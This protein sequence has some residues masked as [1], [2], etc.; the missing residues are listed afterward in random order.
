M[1]DFSDPLGAV[2]KRV[3]EARA[4]L[5]IADQRER[6]AE[7]ETQAADPGLWDDPDA[8]R[9]VTSELAGV[10]DD[11]E[12]VDALTERVDDLDTLFELGREESDESVAPEIETGIES[13][14]SEL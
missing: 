11:I 1:R 7:L 12:L 4:Y 14:R 8:A 9:Q 5:R 6:L 10:R 2:R 13:L 3:D